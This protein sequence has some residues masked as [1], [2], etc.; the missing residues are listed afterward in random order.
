MN[1]FMCLDEL[2]LCVL[3]VHLRT[4]CSD[5]ISCL[6]SVAKSTFYCLVQEAFIC[7]TAC[8]F[9]WHLAQN[10]LTRMTADFEHAVTVGPMNKHCCY[11]ATCGYRRANGGNSTHTSTGIPSSTPPL[12]H[13]LFTHFSVTVR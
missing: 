1:A 13:S 8:I 11:V 4:N 10:R 2:Y 3:M 7:C 5:S 6:L 9:I 12:E